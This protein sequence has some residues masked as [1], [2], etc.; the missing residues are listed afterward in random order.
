MPAEEL[1]QP[2]DLEVLDDEE[3]GDV[4]NVDDSEEDDA[5]ASSENDEDSKE[6]SLEALRA[7]E[8]EQ[9]QRTSGRRPRA[10]SEEEIDIM[11]LKPEADEPITDSIDTIV[12]PMEDR[13]EFVCKG[14][15]LVKPRVQLADRERMLCRDCV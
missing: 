15:Y 6:T 1:E 5:A 7:R 12:T 9:A 4:G 2:E 10:G 11:S 13:Q 8:A 3:D 14:C